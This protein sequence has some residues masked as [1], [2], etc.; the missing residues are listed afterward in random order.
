M[1]MQALYLVEAKTRLILLEKEILALAD[2]IDHAG[3]EMKARYEPTMTDFRTRF[4]EM[5]EDLALLH[6]IDEHE[7]GEFCNELDTA[8]QGLKH[9]VGTARAEFEQQMTFA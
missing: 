2:L 7:W 6:A 8:M 4:K 1:G 9:D 5:G 3:H